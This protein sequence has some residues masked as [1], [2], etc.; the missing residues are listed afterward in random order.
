MRRAEHWFGTRPVDDV[1]E[2]FEVFLL[3]AG[4]GVVAIAGF[5]WSLVL[6]HP[7]RSRDGED[8]KLAR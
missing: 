3:V 6:V 8:Q 7:R 4:M 2:P 1:Q 5:V